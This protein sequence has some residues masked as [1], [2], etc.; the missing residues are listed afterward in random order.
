MMSTA[1]ATVLGDNAR[2]VDAQHVERA[3][4][5][6]RRGNVLLEQEP[7]DESPTYSL[8]RAARRRSTWR[9]TTRPCAAGAIVNAK[10]EADEVPIA[11]ATDVSES[12][13]LEEGD[14]ANAKSQYAPESCP[15]RIAASIGRETAISALVKAGA[16]KSV[17]N[18]DGFSPVQVTIQGPTLTRAR[19]RAVD[20]VV[21]GGRPAPR[22]V[23]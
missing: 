21:N 1:G 22:V 19:R 18:A 4:C 14:E 8:R 7:V 3:Y 9:A 12:G 17:K 5:N 16:D 11:M 2:H 10:T 20:N 13:V 15:L 6:G 23:P